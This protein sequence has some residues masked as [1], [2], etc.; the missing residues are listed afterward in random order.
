MAPIEP[1]TGILSGYFGCKGSIIL[2]KGND[3]AILSTD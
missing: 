1:L 2:S 3:R